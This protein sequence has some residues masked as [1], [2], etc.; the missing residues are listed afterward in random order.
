MPMVRKG[1]DGKQLWCPPVNVL[2]GDCIY[3]SCFHAHDCGHSIRRY[4]GGRWTHNEW[5]RRG[6]CVT[7]YSHGCP[8]SHTI[9]GCCDNPSFRTKSEAA[10]RKC[11][12][13]GVLVPQ[14]IINQIGQEIR[15]HER[16]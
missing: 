3:R 13:C 6:E 12:N 9:R 7:R 14:R 5:V 2:D 11:R 16:K 15:L 4:T 10:S 1:R 8:D